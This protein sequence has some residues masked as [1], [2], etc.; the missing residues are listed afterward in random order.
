MTEERTKKLK[1]GVLGKIKASGQQVAQGADALGSVAVAAFAASL[2]AAAQAADKLADKA[3]E[4]GDVQEAAAQAGEAASKKAQAAS[5]VQ[6]ASALSGVGSA[7]GMMIG[8]PAGA[9]VGSLIGK[10]ASFL[11]GVVEGFQYLTD[12]L[13]ITNSAEE[14]RLAKIKAANAALEKFVSWMLL[15][16]KFDILQSI[17]LHP[18]D[19][20]HAIVIAK[21]RG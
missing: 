9:A 6:A 21:F 12:L 5:Q 14:Q 19:K 7:I 10:L 13:G 16:E 17:D 3:I 1:S 4:A 15:K 20:D 2:N 11:P 8:G 18:Y